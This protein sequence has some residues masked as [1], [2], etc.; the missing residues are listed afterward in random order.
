MSDLMDRIFE[1]VRAERARQ[2]LKFG[3][4]LHPNG[5]SAKFKPMADAARNATRA[6]EANGHQTWTNI[7]REEFWEALSETEWDRLRTELVQVIAVGVAWIEA[8]D[9][10]NG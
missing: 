3:K 8:G 10:Q 7:F 9:E 6:A 5:T 2:D 4:Q 1:E